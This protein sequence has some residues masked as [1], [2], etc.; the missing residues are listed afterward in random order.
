MYIKTRLFA[1]VYCFSVGALS[2]FSVWLLFHVFGHEA[3]RLFPTWVMLIATIYYVCSFFASIF[4][5][6]RSVGRA[7]CP[8]LQSVIVITGILLA[9]FRLVF[10]VGHLKFV[11]IE[12]AGIIL[13]DF[14]LPLLFLIDWILFSKK[15]YWRVVDPFYCL[16]LL[17]CYAAWVLLSAE[18]IKS[19]SLFRYPY[20]ILDFYSIGIDVM[21]WWLIL[22]MVIILALG[23]ICF[24]IDFAMSGKLA[25]HIVLPHIKTIIVEE[26]I[27]IPTKNNTNPS[28]TMSKPSKDLPSKKLPKKTTKVETTRS[29]P[30][31]KKLPVAL[32]EAEA[33][34]VKERTPKDKSH[35][36]SVSTKPAPKKLT[37]K[38]SSKPSSKK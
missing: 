8:T 24:L 31:S 17:V 6:K 25:K 21:L 37:S 3:W 13:V 14:I 26:E 15:G 4:A 36:S 33:R 32:L 18:F 10:S 38:S 29:T 11:G 1:I 35:K 20:T 5:K 9:I 34:S 12:G 28:V 27:S 2:T 22:I 30:K 16:A 19:D 7:L 23:Y